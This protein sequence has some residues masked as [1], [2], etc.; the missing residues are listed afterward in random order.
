M[1]A[2]ASNHEPLVRVQLHD[3]VVE[4]LRR[5]ILT[6]ELAPGSRV[7]EPSLCLRFG[8]SRTPLREALKV[9]AAGGLIE[10]LPNRGARVAPLRVDEIAEA[11]E[12]IA[13]L[14]RRAAELAGGSL[15][16]SVVEDIRHLH[17]ALVTYERVH[18]REAFVQADLRIHRKIVEAAGNR[19]LAAIHAEQALKVERARYL[20]AASDSRLKESLDEHVAI[21]ESVIA[22]DP[23]QISNALYDHCLRTQTALI[24]AIARN[25]ER[26]AGRLSAGQESQ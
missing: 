3:Q 1:R 16:D 18:D 21:L 19:T 4:R 6:G 20:A 7:H 5:L 11:F 15:E 2:G 17:R 12:V 10:L 9:L 8:I 25:A 14:E 26:S 13:I 24:R 23:L 22:R